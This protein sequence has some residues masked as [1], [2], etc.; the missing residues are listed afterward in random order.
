MVYLRG[1]GKEL[2]LCARA[3]TVQSSA[4]ADHPGRGRVMAKE[5]GRSFPLSPFRSLVTDLMAF[6]QKVPAV[7]IDRR[8][9]LSALVAARQ[10]CAARPS[11]CVVFAKAFAL[12]ARSHRHL[13]R[14]YMSFPWGRL[15]EHPYS[16]VALNVERQVGDESI[17]TQCLIKQPDNR[18]LAELD[19]IVRLQQ[20]ESLEEMRW[21]RRALAM[22]KVPWP[23]RQLLWWGA[24]NVFGRRRSHNFGTFSVSSIASQGA[25]L[26]SLIPILSSALH[27]GLFDKSGNLD[28]RMT[29][30]HRVLDG[31]DAARVMVDLERTLQGE[32]LAEVTQLSLKVAA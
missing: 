8:M 14:A 4:I 30:D 11:W 9:D 24:L 3:F 13:R 16:T 27:Y 5:V 6:S 2:L 12:V 15:Y 18:S 25:G 21:Y 19:G 29:F 17:V 28:V 26:L 7:T 1:L 22:S 10:N 31:A 23:I 20:S 32:I